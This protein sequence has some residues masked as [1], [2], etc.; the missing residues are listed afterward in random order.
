M[1]LP[2]TQLLERVAQGDQRALDDVFGDLYPELRRIAHNRLYAQGRPLDMNTTQLVHENF[3][4]MVESK[5]IALGD[6]HHFFSYAAKVM[7][8]II[9]DEARAIQADCRG[10]GAVHLTLSGADA[11]A[12]DDSEPL[13]ADIHD[14]LLTLERM[15]AELAEIV[16][17]RYFGGYGDM[18]I[19]ELLGLSERTVRRR[20]DKA[21][22]L[23]QLVLE[24]DL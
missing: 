10:G 6:R 2:I 9:V 19:A 8:N 21:R 23:L 13:V 18:D 20:W 24:K 14:A 12:A 1:N 17:M 5:S 4:R 16:E 7:R 15:D 11:L 3:L 22:G